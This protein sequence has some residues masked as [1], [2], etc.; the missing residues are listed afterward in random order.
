MSAVEIL[1]D[2]ATDGA[3]LRVPHGP[4]LNFTSAVTL[5]CWANILDR[6][7]SF[8]RIWG[9]STPTEGEPFSAW[10]LLL[11]ND[12][13][14][15]LRMEVA[16]D[17]VKTPLESPQGLFE[18]GVWTHF[19]GTYD[20]ASMRLYIN[21]A[22]VASAAQ[23]GSM[24]ANTVDVT[25][26]GPNWADDNALSARLADCRVYS[27]ALSL[28]EIQTLYAEPRGPAISPTLLNG[29]VVHAAPI[30][31]PIYPANASLTNGAQISE[32]SPYAAAATVGGFSGTAASGNIR[33]FPQPA[34]TLTSSGWLSSKTNHSPLDS[35][36]DRVFLM[37]LSIDNWNVSG[38]FESAT[39][40]G[41]ALTVEQYWFD[42]NSAVVILTLDEAGLS[43]AINT[44]I[45]II[46]NSQPTDPDQWGVAHAIYENAGVMGA[47]AETT[48]TGGGGT[49][50]QLS[51]ALSPQS[52]GLG[53]IFAIVFE[54]RDG[55]TFTADD[56]FTQAAAIDIPN[57]ATV[58]IFTRRTI[59]SDLNPTITSSSNL[60]RWLRVFEMRPS[61]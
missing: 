23:T 34:P 53:I 43:A 5:S 59:R 47:A 15:R 36:R 17:G 44:S 37:V 9:K 56:G 60:V 39:Y 22:E 7:S 45:L 41:Q 11:E 14:P 24:T 18:Y 51:P 61:A 31:S 1:N 32:V 55:T 29:L 16:L 27:R 46:W 33:W 42:D 50:I 57:T 38:A 26:A 54:D 48:T 21:G 35:G 40:G 13:P 30:T 19:A 8:E 58:G 28:S 52:L 3:R 49:T 6:T 12:D 20:G 10:M 2:S 25:G 4:H